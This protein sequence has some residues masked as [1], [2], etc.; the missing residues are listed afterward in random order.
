MDVRGPAEGPVRAKREAGKS[1][2]RGRNWKEASVVE[3]CRTGRAGQVSQR[4]LQGVCWDPLQ[5]TTWRAG[6]VPPV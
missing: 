6:V 1:F 2:A 4:P 3:W 5:G